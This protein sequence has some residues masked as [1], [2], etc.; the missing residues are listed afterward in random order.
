[1][2]HDRAHNFD[3]QFTRYA[4]NYFSLDNLFAHYSS[5]LAIR[6]AFVSSSRTSD[7]LQQVSEFITLMYQKSI[8]WIILD[9]FK[10]Q[11]RFIIVEYWGDLYRFAAIPN[12]LPSELQHFDI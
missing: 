8:E 9:V 3:A 11:F 4:K 2:K 5:D 6:K 10:E 1:M 7:R 12:L